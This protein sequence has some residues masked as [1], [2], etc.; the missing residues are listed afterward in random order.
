VAALP[1]A[2]RV[3]DFGCG[4][5]LLLRSARER[6]LDAVGYDV[7]ERALR[8]CTE[9]G[10]KVTDRLEDLQ[11][12]EFDAIV[13]HHVFEHLDRPGNVLKGVARLLA[14]RG[15][16]FIEVPNA[17]SLRARLSHPVL[18]RYFHFDER[19]RAFPI[20][21]SYFS[22][23]SLKRLLER[24]GFRVNRVAT[25]GLGIDELIVSSSASDEAYGA[26]TLA[27]YRG[28]IVRPAREFV[29]RKLYGAG[30][31]ENLLVVAAPHA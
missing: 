18:S 19:Y 7:G 26:A 15:S 3:L 23:R 14:P 31:G 13:L 24:H 5:G 17:A 11:D 29:K 8:T 6:G 21:L 1:N 2:R 4:G 22:A 25:Y 20:H 30:L 16:M 28:G 12:G 9:Q 10:L 27:K